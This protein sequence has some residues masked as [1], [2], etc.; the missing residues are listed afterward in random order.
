MPARS[1]AVA[2]LI[3][4]LAINS[5]ARADDAA[6]TAE[7]LA[8][9]VT[10]AQLRQ[11]LGG[12]DGDG[13]VVCGGEVA[14]DCDEYASHLST[15][16]NEWNMNCPRR[17]GALLGQVRIETSSLN[18]EFLVQ[19][20]GATSGALGLAVDII[21]DACRDITGLASVV[22]GAFPGCGNSDPC[23]CGSDAEIGELLALPDHIW[24]VAGWYFAEG[25]DG[26]YDNE[27][28]GI[29]FTPCQDLRVYA[30]EGI[31]IWP[32]WVSEG[33]PGSGFYRVSS[34]VNGI[35]FDAD[36]DARTRW[37]SHAVQVWDNSFP[38]QCHDGQ[39]TEPPSDGGHV[40]DTF[41]YD[42]GVDCGGVCAAGCLAG[43]PCHTHGEC[44]SHLE[45]DAETNSEGL[46]VDPHAAC[47]AEQLGSFTADDLRALMGGR[48][49]NCDAYHAILEPLLLE[50]RMDCPLRLSALVAQMRHETDGFRAFYSPNGHKG[51]A[52]HLPPAS[53]RAACRANSDIREA[54]EAHFSGDGE[55]VHSQCNAAAGNDDVCDCGSSEEVGLIAAGPEVAFLS[56]VWWFAEGA[57]DEHG[58][59]CGDLR[60]AADV[61]VGQWEGWVSSAFPGEGYHRISTCVYGFSADEGREQ[62]QQFYA[63][64]RQHF[65]ANYVDPCNNGVQDAGE[66]DVDCGARCFRAKLCPD[67]AGCGTGDDCASQVCVAGGDG[68]TCKDRS[69]DCRADAVEDFDEAAFTAI[70]GGSANCGSDG[71]ACEMLWEPFWD[72][73]AAH[74]L[75]CPKRLAGYVAH[76]RLGSND[77]ID[78][79]GGGAIT[80]PRHPVTGEI[81]VRTACRRIP[82]LRDAFAAAFETSCY[83]VNVEP[84]GCGTTTEAESIAASPEFAFE[85]AAWF[86]SG[87]SGEL[88]NRWACNDARFDFD[89]GI[90]ISGE[91]PSAEDPGTGF[92]RTV[93]CAYGMSDTNVV[94]A[95]PMYTTARQVYDS[96]FV[97]PSSCANGIKDGD[98][99]D[100]DCGGAC[101]TGCAVDEMCRID[102]DCSSD[103]RCW[104]APQGSEEAG[105]CSDP[106]EPCDSGEAPT[107]D[108]NGI[109]V[110]LGAA[111]PSVCAAAECNDMSADIADA[112][113]AYDLTCPLRAAAFLSLVG[114]LTA[115]LTQLSS[116]DREAPR[117]SA[118][119]LSVPDLRAACYDVPRLAD[120]AAA[121]FPDCGGACEC[122]TAEEFAALAAAAD[123]AFHVAAWWF[124]G[125][126]SCG[127]LRN[128]ADVGTPLPGYGFSVGGYTGLD[129]YDALLQDAPG[130][131]IYHTQACATQWR[132]PSANTTPQALARYERAR[133]SVDAGFALPPS[134]ANGVQDGGETDVDCGGSTSQCYTRCGA[135]D[136]CAEDADCAGASLCLAGVC[137]DP[138]ADCQAESLT[139]TVEQLTQAMGG[140]C[141]HCATMLPHVQTA[142]A[143]AGM[144]CPLR[145]ADFL[146][147][148]RHE[149]AKMTQFTNPTDNGAG[150]LHVIPQN[151]RY[152][153]RELP[154]LESAFSTAFSSCS[155]TDKCAC[156]TDAQA[157]SVLATP[158]NAFRIATWWYSRG[159]A[160]LMGRPC[161]D[162]RLEQDIGVGN[163]GTVTRT[164]PGSGYHKIAACTFGFQPDYG[165]A[166][167]MAFYG[168]ARAVFDPEFSLQSNCLT[169]CPLGTVETSPCDPGDAKDRVCTP[170]ADAPE[171]GEGQAIECSCPAGFEGEDCSDI[172]DE[173][174]SNDPCQNGGT[175]VD[176]VA[177]VTCD[178]PATHTGAHCEQAV[179]E[180]ATCTTDPCPGGSFESEGCSCQSDRTCSACTVCGAGEWEA[181]PCSGSRDAVCKPIQVCGEDTFERT[182]PT[183]TSDRECV[184]CT[185]CDTD[186][187]EMIAS[188]CM[189]DADR[190][191]E[192]CSECPADYETVYECTATEDAVCQC[193]DTEEDNCVDDCENADQLCLNGATCNDLLNEHSCDCADG[194]EGDRC[195]HNIDDCALLEPCQ[196]GATCVDG[197]GGIGNFTC[198]CLPG[199]EGTECGELV[200]DAP[201]AFMGADGSPPSAVE[202]G[203][204]AVLQVVLTAQPSHAVNISFTVVPAEQASVLPVKLVFGPADWDVPQFVAVA[205]TVDLV[206]EADEVNVTVVA[207]TLSSQAIFDAAT[208]DAVVTTVDTDVAGVTVSSAVVAVDEGGTVEVEVSLDTRPT[209][210]VT[211]TGAVSD[212][213]GVETLELPSPFT[214]VPA[215][216]E[217]DQVVEVAVTAV[218]DDIVRAAAS[219]DVTVTYTASSSDIHYDGMSFD[220]RYTITEDDSAGV[221]ARPSVIELLEDGPAVPYQVTL[222]SEPLHDVVVTVDLELHGAADDL[223]VT[224]TELTF[225]PDSWDVAQSVSVHGVADNRT[226][227]DVQTFRIAHQVASADD[228]Y[229]GITADEVEVDVTD[230]DEAHV[231]VSWL[232]ADGGEIAEGDSVGSTLAVR[233]TSHPVAI[234]DVTLSAPDFIVLQ[235]STLTFSA[236]DNEW[237][238]FQHVVVSAANDDVDYGDREATIS[239]AAS[240]ADDH[241]DQADAGEIQVVVSDDDQASL[242]VQVQDDGEGAL[243]EGQAHA[244]S[245][246][247]WLGTSPLDDVV[248]T[249]D[250]GARVQATPA[251]VTFAAG[252]DPAV[253]AAVQLD[254]ADNSV[255]EGTSTEVTITA[256]A[257]SDDAAY[258]GL[259]D[260]ATVTVLDNDTSGVEAHFANGVATVTEGSEDDARLDVVLTSKPASAVTVTMMPGSRLQCTPGQLTFSPADWD[261]V[262]S[263]SVRANDN[264]I[265]EDDAAGVITLSTTSDD[266]RY[267]IANAATGGIVVVDDDAS[268]VAVSV[269]SLMLE[270]DG[271]T[272]NSATYELVLESQPTDRVTV[273]IGADAAQVTVEPATVVFQVGAWDVPQVVTVTA[274][275][276]GADNEAP[277]HDAQLTHTVSSNDGNY[278]GDS[279]AVASV[280]VTIF[281]RSSDECESS[282]CLN[283]G[284]CIDQ[285]GGYNC[286]CAADWTGPSCGNFVGS[287]DTAGQI[288]GQE[289]GPDVNDVGDT[290]SSTMSLGLVVVVV[291]GAIVALALLVG[292]ARRWRKRKEEQSYSKVTNVTKADTI[293]EDRDSVVSDAGSR[294]GSAQSRPGSSGSRR[295]RPSQ[296]APTDSQPTS[297]PTSATTLRRVVPTFGS[298]P[299]MGADAAGD[300]GGYEM[301]PLGSVPGTPRSGSPAADD[302][303]ADVQVVAHPDDLSDDDGAEEV[304][305]AT[306]AGAGAQQ[307]AA[308]GRSATAAPATFKLPGPRPSSG[309]LRATA[310]VPKG[311]W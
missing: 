207:T 158:E 123:T 31:G 89:V 288:A 66:P 19:G 67:G 202:G 20:D 128:D 126:G 114:G 157:A 14:A 203:D 253:P 41:K 252:S 121:A 208:D 43:E 45:C 284:T 10:G 249:V 56:A 221:T 117:A 234:V 28:G 188:A 35:Q 173:C 175:C 108:A 268:G 204:D 159:S 13:A 27:V 21:R 100:V 136:G 62:R 267:V 217:P 240:S 32:G 37:S 24:R 95:P 167:R 169:S 110:L 273:S 154:W 138:D 297:R 260:S 141:S 92:Y 11:A 109:A 1:A 279:V 294:P 293:G 241:Y 264:D 243:E 194:F 86:L 306:V 205:A 77:L 247:I 179:A 232:D 239:V 39:H 271:E 274:V 69:A 250:G 233:L 192:A 9:P 290:D 196:N 184:P 65:D 155:F 53:L 111:D 212:G 112:M 118:L 94:E 145:T 87:G 286:V 289:T 177:G 178:C 99:S 210:D 120:A 22:D 17:V 151:F 198:L 70:M 16:L 224:P 218:D 144:D 215:T 255:D 251:S 266:P 18:P 135:G 122:G 285:I 164:S 238:A 73:A 124:T 116:G 133:S 246:E 166:Q 305:G 301:G 245:L 220:V 78:F 80:L 150:A 143:E 183:A 278:N 79:S 125:G 97:Q 68:G 148:V 230:I 139:L 63:T 171:D 272:T 98:E 75:V 2:L 231:S 149:T 131:G 102:S 216:W 90:G 59:A 129:G 103:L 113:A 48:C 287:D 300:D 36:R 269:A 214:F 7:A 142:L 58:T 280:T 302:D 134:C 57:A 44:A 186:G 209:Q 165:G 236:D 257:A 64:A 38:A 258:D 200:A 34:C 26:R 83:S 50:Y 193:I 227:P 189:P 211:W 160:E 55:S 84:C 308:L 93:A 88:V 61:G 72:A 161:G 153:C 47:A 256:V 276:D 199:F 304:R 33:S 261:V 137:T 190:V 307:G 222:T 213:E 291:L 71:T 46:C 51:G 180:C 6:C 191:C 25:A 225:S 223:E 270:E 119:L 176:G 106:R 49:F 140:D 259:D 281:D 3:V 244:L 12:G 296:V 23:T 206:D 4:I 295:S 310:S 235:P 228:A 254:A 29:N 309:K 170:C 311:A 101:N 162:L 292:G 265:D 283:G 91:P 82:A 52:L 107:L 277:S 74:G 60:Y 282:P 76:V 303:D 195:H 54:F 40:A 219:H 182:P 85:T 298:R 30:D 156:G 229:D 132:A 127:D 146:A 262:Q 96:L 201:L 226:E 147:A 242:H 187:G 130:S 8:G 172:V 81:G 181:R 237:S 42:S 248:V 152:A 115:D 15:A 263:T 197:F 104:E 5:S 275:N 163:A 105:I 299:D 174:A 168:E 185:V